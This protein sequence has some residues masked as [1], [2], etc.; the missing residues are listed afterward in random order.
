MEIV[1]PCLPSTDGRHGDSI[2]MPPIYRFFAPMGVCR[3]FNP[4]NAEICVCKPWRP[5]GLY[6]LKSSL[7]DKYLS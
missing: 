1:S 5:K 2:P 6:N 3:V 7:S 4:D